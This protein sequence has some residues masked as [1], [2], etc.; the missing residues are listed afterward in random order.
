M[1]H[2]R[3]A[4]AAVLCALAL[5]APALGASSHDYD[6]YP[7]ESWGLPSD[8]RARPCAERLMQLQVRYMQ[9]LGWQVEMPLLRTGDA[10]VPDAF[11]ATFEWAGGWWVVLSPDTEKAWCRSLTRLRRGLPV[12]RRVHF[13][14]GFH[15]TLHQIYDVDQ[16]PLIYRLQARLARAF[17]SDAA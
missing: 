8:H 5:S 11:A 16:H 13:E 3:K 17:L 9:D 14:V 10:P 2:L 6:D 7:R 1:T 15:E 12:D 4:A